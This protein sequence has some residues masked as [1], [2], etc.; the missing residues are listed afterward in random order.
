MKQN[1]CRSRAKIV[2]KNVIKRK[3]LLLQIL[4]GSDEKIKTI[5]W[6]SAVRTRFG[7]LSL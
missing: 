3:K 2:F 6:F 4:L 1:Q 5:C 7:S